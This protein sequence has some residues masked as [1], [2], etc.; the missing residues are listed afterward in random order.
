ME[1]PACWGA[2]EVYLEAEEGEESA[3]QRPGGREQEPVEAWAE[4]L[5]VE[6]SERAWSLLSVV[7]R[8]PGPGDRCPR[9]SQCRGL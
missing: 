5:E 6:S 1:E 7:S 4:L 9:G 2:G 3:E 8:G